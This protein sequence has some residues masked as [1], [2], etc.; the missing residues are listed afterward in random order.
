M[1]LR[2]N[3]AE[4]NGESDSPSDAEETDAVHASILDGVHVSR[5]VG[6]LEFGPMIEH[7]RSR[8]ENEWK[9]GLRV[10]WELGRD[11]K[12]VAQLVAPDPEVRVGLAREP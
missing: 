3:V 9:G 10:A 1:S 4:A 8:E 12:L 11:F 2:A 5:L 6:R 7:I